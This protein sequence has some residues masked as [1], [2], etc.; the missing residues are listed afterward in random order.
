VDEQPRPSLRRVWA[1][2]D[3][4]QGIAFHMDE[5]ISLLDT[6]ELLLAQLSGVS[7]VAILNA[8]A[9][10]NKILDATGLWR[11][12]S[13]AQDA[14][15]Q[16]E[17]EAELC[18]LTGQEIDTNMGRLQLE[19]SLKLSAAR[20]DHMVENSNAGYRVEIVE[21]HLESVHS[22]IDECLQ[23]AH[24]QLLESGI[25]GIDQQSADNSDDGDGGDR[26]DDNERLRMVDHSQSLS[27]PPPRGA[28]DD[29]GSEVSPKAGTVCW[30]GGKKV[31]FAS[32]RWVWTSKNGASVFPFPEEENTTIEDA[33]SRFL[34]GGGRT[35]RLEKHFI[36]FEL[37]RQIRTD[38]HEHWRVVRRCR[39]GIDRFEPS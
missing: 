2:K 35:V 38:S 26:T 30:I 22:R 10:V 15:Q 6:N 31:P 9:A 14:R 39:A 8:L 4:A 21:D 20:I 5:L 18:Q 16:L 25:G 23:C 3:A 28:G 29:H 17:A 37:M 1:A 24:E 32:G 13:S 27:S 11:G 33:F 34:S 19:V 36:D 12:H 7:C